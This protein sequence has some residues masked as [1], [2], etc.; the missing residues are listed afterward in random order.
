MRAIILA[1]GRG[2]RMKAL[3]SDKPKCLVELR[4]HSLLEL[5]LDAL[6]EGGVSEI[7]IVTGYRRELLANL[8][9]V[10]FHNPRWDETNMVS[11]LECAG[12]WLEAGP[13][14]VSYSDIF[15]SADAVRSLINCPALLAVTYDPTWLALWTRRFGDPLLDAET[16]LRSTAGDREQ[17]AVCRRGSGPV[18]G[19]APFYHVCLAGGVGPAGCST[20]R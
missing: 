8:G 3:T 18:H 5:Q 7:G 10:E 15:Y 2:S 19:L 17:T 12:A 1:A 11:S 14:I 4:G 20:S 9:L 16:F 6:R 13:C